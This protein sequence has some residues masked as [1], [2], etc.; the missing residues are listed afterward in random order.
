M[1]PRGLE[2]WSA[3]TVDSLLRSETVSG[4]IKYQKTYSKDYLS[5]KQVRNKG[6][7]PNI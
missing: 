5:K 1:S 6:N 7:Y 3:N 2:E 4:R